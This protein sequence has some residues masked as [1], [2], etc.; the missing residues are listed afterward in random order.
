[1]KKGLQT[2][3]TLA[4]IG[5]A[6]GIMILNSA[7]LILETYHHFSS[8]HERVPT[9][10]PILKLSLHFEQSL[11]RSILW[12]TLFAIGLA[13]TV[14]IYVAKR[15]TTPLVEMR[16]V[17]EQIVRGNLTS[18]VTY[19]GD[20]E[21][22]DLGRALNHL[23]EQLQ[24]QEEL[25]K[26]LTADV[27]H[28]LRTPL[29]TLKSHMEA[30]KDGVWEPTPERIQSC[31]EEI[32]R[33]THLVSDVEQLTRLESPGFSLQRSWE[34]LAD[35]ARQAV[36]SQQ[37]AYVQKGVA[38]EVKGASSV[39][40]NLDRKRVTQIIVNLLSNALKYTPAGGSVTVTVEEGPGHACLKVSDTGI[41][42]DPSEIPRVFERFYR[43]DK[44]RNGNPAAAVS[45]WP[46]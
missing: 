23:T 5:I 4:F 39:W 22:T 37:A 21:L 19:R 33:L 45:V 32:E 29:A 28:E 16:K 10:H 3:L 13:V 14:S 15:I 20:D 36:Y 6:S 42:M 24:K 7:V 34:D 30:F 31:Y 43:T 8:Y 12:T 17:A 2:R 44:S 25:R 40:V 1:M 27:A 38:L 41:G 11:I 26:N 46:W 35:I 18:R 9:G